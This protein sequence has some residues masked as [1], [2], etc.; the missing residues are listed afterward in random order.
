MTAEC[1]V[2]IILTLIPPSGSPLNKLCN[3]ETIAYG[4]ICFLHNYTVKL[5]NLDDAFWTEQKPLI[6]L[7]N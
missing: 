4:T 6:Q 1:F 7:E 2:A 3:P 5:P